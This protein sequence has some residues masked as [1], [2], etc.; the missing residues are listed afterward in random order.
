MSIFAYSRHA[1]YG[2]AL[3]SALSAWTAQAEVKLTITEPWVRA[4]VPQQPATGAFMTLT[5]DQDARL[6]AVESPVA[7]Q[8]EIHEMRMENDIMRMRQI[9]GL[10]LPRGQKVEL[11]PG[12]YHVMLI[13]L[14][15]PVTASQTVPLTLVVEDRQGQRQTIAVDAPVQALGAQGAAHGHGGVGHHDAR[16]GHAGQAGHGS[17]APKEDGHAPGG[18]SHPP[19]AAAPG[20]TPSAHAA[21]A[22]HSDSAKAA[23]GLPV[24]PESLEVSDCWVRALPAPLPSAAYLQI[25]NRGAAPLTLTTASAPGF[26]QVMLHQTRTADGVASM[27]HVHGVAVAPG[28]AVALE[29]GGYHVML[30]EPAG[31]LAVGKDLTLTLGFEGHAP[32]PVDCEVRSARG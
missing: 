26:G 11:R 25:R 30:E 14:H 2:L 21:H 6:V 9:P 7:K 3:F 4:T 20:G 15:A 32:R 5:A 23:H 24:L 12:G 10:D 18:A 31:E 28:G 29:P 16:Q 8:V 1:A 13:G 27:H 19:A 17:A 22:A